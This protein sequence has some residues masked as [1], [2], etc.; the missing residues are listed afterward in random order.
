MAEK[1][2]EFVKPQNQ[3]AVRRQLTNDKRFRRL[4]DQWVGSALKPARLEL[5][6]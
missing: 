6:K 2:S 5:D 3:K 1:N 4:T